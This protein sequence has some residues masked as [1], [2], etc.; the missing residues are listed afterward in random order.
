MVSIEILKKK[1]EINSIHVM[2]RSSMIYVCHVWGLKFNIFHL[3]KSMYAIHRDDKVLYG[4][5]RVFEKIV[6]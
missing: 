4:E 3:K 2:H 5:C 6:I 1:A